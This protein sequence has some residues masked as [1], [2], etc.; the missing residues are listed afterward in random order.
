MV[1]AVSEKASRW[2]PQETQGGGHRRRIRA[3]AVPLP[4]RPARA[5]GPLRV[6]RAGHAGPRLPLLH[7][8]AAQPPLR[9]AE[10][11]AV[12]LLADALHLAPL[13]PQLRRDRR[14]CLH[15]GLRGRPRRPA[16][17]RRRP[18]PGHD[19]H[20]QQAAAAG[21]AGG[22]GAADHGAG[23]FQGPGARDGRARGGGGGLQRLRAADQGPGAGVRLAQE[24]ALAADPALRRPR[25][26]HV[27]HAPPGHQVLAAGQE[28]GKGRHH[29]PRLR[30]P[31]A[32]RTARAA[33]QRRRLALR[34]WHHRV[35]PPGPA[36]PP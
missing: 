7:R 10:Q 35:G 16:L 13:A 5:L 12:R 3:G 29:R 9:R 26:R 22:A 20:G 30:V 19:A 33:P 14:A 6:P 2:I 15:Q 31:L 28:Q 18:A 36:L 23:G 8:P 4:P 32:P 24:G 27:P 17:P 1:Y 25:R 21:R 34:G 11:R